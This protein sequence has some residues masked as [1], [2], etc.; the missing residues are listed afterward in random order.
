MPANGLR[1]LKGRVLSVQSHVVHG[2]VG[3]KAATFPLQL[4]GF[5]VDPLNT[6]QFSNHTGYPKFTGDRFEGPQIL[7][8]LEGI[9]ANGFLKDYTHLLTGYVGR[10][11]SLAVIVDLAKKMK[12]SNPDIIFF[13]DPVMGDEGKL[14]VP[15][16]LVPIY[17]DQLCPLADIVTPNSFE[18]EILSG[19]KITSTTTAFQALDAIHALGAKTAIITSAILSDR[20]PTSNLDPSST[21]TMHMI[22]STHATSPPTRFLIAFPR[23]RALFTGTGD[24]LSALLLA[25]LGGGA[26]TDAA[27]FRAACERAVASMQGVLAA[28]VAFYEEAANGEGEADLGKVMKCRELLVVQSRDCI[29]SPELGKF[30]AEDV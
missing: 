10:E 21:G 20:Q 29:E 8:L 4:L 7:K 1:K 23:I 18:A 9:E 14:Y 27:S 11:S 26:V 12:A 30:K 24:L 3:N 15:S 25:N 2:I 5:E 22:A 28:T 6:V 17:R 19:T 16:E 13:L